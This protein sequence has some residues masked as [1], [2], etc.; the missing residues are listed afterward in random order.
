MKKTLGLKGQC[1]EISGSIL[2]NIYTKWDKNW[3]F[4]QPFQTLGKESR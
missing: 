4:E 3:G 1:L 2:E